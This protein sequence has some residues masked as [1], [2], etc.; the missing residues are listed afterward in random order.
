MDKTEKLTYAAR[1]LRLREL[2]DARPFVTVKE[3]QQTFGVSRKTV[4]ND[5]AALQEAK[6]PIHSVVGPAGEARWMLEQT[7]KKKTITMA[8][9][10]AVPLG[11]ARLALSFLEGT[12][13]HDQLGA[14]MDKLAEGATPATMTHLAGLDRKVAIVPHGPKSYSRKADVLDNLLT[15]L[16][17]DQRVEIR[18]RPA[19]GGTKKHVIE[20]LSLVLY[21]EALYLIARSTT[22]GGLQITFAVDRITRSEW[23]K[24]QHFDYPTDFDPKQVFDGVF[25]LVGG[26]PVEVEIAFDA[27]QAK[28]VRERRWHPS[29]RFDKLADGRVRMRM[30]VS[31]TS[32]VALWLLGHAG[33]FEVVSPPALRK[34]VQATLRRAVGQHK[35]ARGAGA[36]RPG[37]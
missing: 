26:E 5:L 18:Y 29:Q 32:D 10:Q 7:A 3:L 35:G 22:Y 13:V 33:S 4:Y 14:V 37:R 30:T 27:E 1:V 19:A 28:Y 21:R 24:G 11:L 20:P 15:G 23:L 17:Y 36:K 2:F 16:L 31:G 25:G 12:E 34:E 8:A 6:V 9:G